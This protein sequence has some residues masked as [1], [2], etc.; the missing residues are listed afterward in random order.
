MLRGG[1]VKASLA[2]IQFDLS[3]TDSTWSLGSGRPA[4]HRQ[5]KLERV[6]KGA[7]KMIKG[8]ENVT[9]EK[10]LRELD[11]FNLQ[12]RRPEGDIITI[13]LLYKGIL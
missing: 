13:L 5:N 8:L 2:V 1:H 4:F 7:S 9:H 6:L 11:T 10:R 3:W 12:K